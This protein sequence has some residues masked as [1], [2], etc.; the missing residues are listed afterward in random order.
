[1]IFTS[2]M[3]KDVQGFYSFVSPARAARAVIPQSPRQSI[4]VGQDL[5]DLLV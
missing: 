4:E 3:G 5:Q 2:G 1:M